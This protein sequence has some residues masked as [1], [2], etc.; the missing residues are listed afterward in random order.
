MKCN[1][2]QFWNGFP[3]RK[4]FKYVLIIIIWSNNANYIQNRKRDQKKHWCTIQ[5][6]P[7][8]KLNRAKMKNYSFRSLCSPE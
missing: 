6:H 3:P 2:M 5:T 4:Q 8:Y 7:K 1:K